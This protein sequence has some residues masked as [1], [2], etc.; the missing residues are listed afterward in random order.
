MIIGAFEQQAVGENIPYFQI[1]TH[2]GDGVGENFL[3]VCVKIKIGHRFTFFIKRKKPVVMTS[4][5][6]VLKQR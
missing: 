5:L 3:G 4:L 6:Y 2:W 1:N